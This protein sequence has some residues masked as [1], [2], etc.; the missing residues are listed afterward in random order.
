MALLPFAMTSSPMLMIPAVTRLHWSQ[1]VVVDADDGVGDIYEH[2]HAAS[3]SSAEPGRDGTGLGRSTDDITVT[4]ACSRADSLLSR[5]TVDQAGVGTQTRPERFRVSS[6]TDTDTD[7]RA[8]RR[9][10]RSFNGY[11]NVETTCAHG[12]AGR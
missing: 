10:S 8:A 7:P 9:A 3:I 5:S 2:G 12:C 4:A 6:N 11:V 1:C